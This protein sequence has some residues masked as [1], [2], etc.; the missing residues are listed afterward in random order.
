MTIY[1]NTRG[2]VVAAVG[3]INFG[4]DLER[5]LHL[6]TRHTHSHNIQTRTCAS[7]Y[8]NKYVGH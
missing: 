5:R 8:E 3:A 6:L 4:T 7:R 2:V 1:K